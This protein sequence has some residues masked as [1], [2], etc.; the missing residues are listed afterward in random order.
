MLRAASLRP[1]QFA[2]GGRLGIVYKVAILAYV[3]AVVILSY[4]DGLT[5]FAK[6]AALVL[7]GL[8]L[9][10]AI[11]SG[12]K[13]FLPVEYKL[14]FGWLIVA[15]VSSAISASPETAFSRILTL[16]QVYPIA[17]VLSNMIVWNGDTRFYWLCIVTAAAL[18]GV[19]T[20][21]NPAQFSD[22]DG[23]IFGTLDNANAFAALLA[24]SIGLTLSQV[25]NTRSMLVRL[26]CLGLVAF[27]AYLVGRTGSRMGM[28]ASF[29]AVVT[30]VIC[31]QAGRKGR[32]VGKTVFLLGLGAAVVAGGAFLLTSSEFAD[33]YAALQ[34]SLETGDF[35]A[36]GDMSLYGRA[37]L[38]QKGFEIFLAN[39]LLGVG[40]DVFRTAQLEFRTIGN[41]SHSNYLEILAGTGLVGGICYFAMYYHWWSKLMGARALLREPGM[42]VHM[43][44]AFTI[45]V[46]VLVQDVAWVSYYEKLTLLVLAGLIAE[47]NLL[48]GAKRQLGQNPLARYL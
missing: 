30:V 40:L 2:G 13:V 6:G 35:R 38:Y 1:A 21:A 27:F 20:I 24:V 37:R 15:V 16:L 36:S 3:L 7:A 25:A 34:L 19:V 32:L 29:A 8:F 47:V 14:L 43:T 41:N 12:E 5:F 33:R 44:A 48:A 10:R 45:A 18:S 9:L 4:R 26:L 23:R 11:A 46:V 17:F 39:P 31:Y 22:L 42:A 28:L